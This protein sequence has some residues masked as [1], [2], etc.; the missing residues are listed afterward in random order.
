MINVF[1]R[2]LKQKT[3]IHNS[4]IITYLDIFEKYFTANFS[5]K[6]LLKKT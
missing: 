3:K 6:L 4:F 2:C 1:R 5:Q